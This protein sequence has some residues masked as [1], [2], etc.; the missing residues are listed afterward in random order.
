MVERQT[1][2][3]SSPPQAGQELTVPA[4][5]GFPP[6]RAGPQG[7]RGGPAFRD[8]AAFYERLGEEQYL[9][10]P[11][12]RVPQLERTL[13]S[14]FGVEAPVFVKIEVNRTG[15][16]KDRAAALQVIH[17]KEAG[18]KTIAAP[19]SGSFAESIAFY[20]QE[21]GLACHLFM[22]RDQIS[23]RQRAR[24]EG[25]GAT[26]HA[27]RG[28][29]Y[30]KAV[31]ACQ[32]FS[33]TQTEKVYDA[34]PGIVSHGIDNRALQLQANAM[35]AIELKAQLE[36]HGHEEI[37]LVAVPAG[38]GT[39]AAGLREGFRQC[40]T[41]PRLFV[42]TSQNPIAKAALRGS[43]DCKDLT[44]PIKVTV[45][46]EAGAGSS[47]V[48]GALA[49]RAVRSSGGAV[50]DVNSSAI[51]RAWRKLNVAIAQALS[52]FERH[53]IRVLPFAAAGLA[54]MIQYPELLKA[55]AAG[56][57]KP[58]QGP[59]VLIVSGVEDGGH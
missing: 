38:N 43:R 46:N 4:R 26:I 36:Q 42:A 12:L 3:R 6:P 30:D 19:S 39:L 53:P 5:E 44:E 41:N 29:D 56:K 1:K 9:H 40:V 28:N 18:L 47:A 35:L 50:V 59:I 21:E 17:A 13:K 31:R 14:R 23:A 34:S 22:P 15:T 7:L 51:E 37:G 45:L 54:G 24:L 20:A 33:K 11:L 32:R 49:I 52:C 10:S 25:L 2:I 27:V 55:I 48:D 8:F 57:R 58:L 16:F